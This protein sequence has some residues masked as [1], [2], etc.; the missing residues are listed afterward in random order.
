[1]VVLSH[2]GMNIDRSDSVGSNLKDS[3][4]LCLESGLGESR[5]AEKGW[6]CLSMQLLSRVCG[7]SSPRYDGCNAHMCLLYG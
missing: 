1:M 6:I 5:A 7:W 2:S 4:L 3:P